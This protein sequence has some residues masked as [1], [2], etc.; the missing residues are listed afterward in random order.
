MLNTYDN[1]LLIQYFRQ[2]PLLRNSMHFNIN[3]KVTVPPFC[4]VQI[5]TQWLRS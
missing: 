1:I 2:R 4:T 5:V 3:Y